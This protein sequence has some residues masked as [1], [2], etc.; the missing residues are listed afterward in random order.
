MKHIIP[1]R[2][3]CILRN[4]MDLM[5]EKNVCIHTMHV[6][7]LTLVLNVNMLTGCTYKGLPCQPYL[8][9]FVFVPHMYKEVY[10]VCLLCLSPAEHWFDFNEIC[11]QISILKL[12]VQNIV[13]LS[14]ASL[15]K[16][17]VNFSVY[18]VKY[19]AKV[20][21]IQLDV[22]KCNKYSMFFSFFF[23]FFCVQKFD[24]VNSL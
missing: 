21:P 18:L 11:Y 7:L 6:H 2:N 15:L 17:C 5:F 19:S 4:F 13:L 16:A 22:W 20:K 8:G 24:S 23:F 10:S 9:C 1:V 14:M 3:I 12:N